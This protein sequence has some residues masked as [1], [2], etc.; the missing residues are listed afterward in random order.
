MCDIGKDFRLL[1][2]DDFILE[3]GSIMWMEKGTVIVTEECLLS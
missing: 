1:S 2:L 3:G